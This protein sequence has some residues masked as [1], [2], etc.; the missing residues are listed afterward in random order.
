MLS[1]IIPPLNQIKN[2][3]ISPLMLSLITPMLEKKL[4]NKARGIIH[5][6]MVSVRQPLS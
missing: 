2:K 3:K 5:M 1:L 4:L 6:N